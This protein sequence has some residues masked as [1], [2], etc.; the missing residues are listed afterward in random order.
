M[1]GDKPAQGVPVVAAPSEAYGPDRKEVARATTDYEGNYRLTGVPVGRYSV[2]PLAPTM[3]GP[4]DPM[5]GVNGRL[6][7]IGEGETVEKIDFS[8]TRGG[9]ITGR[10]TD[11]DGKPVI[12]ERLQLNA[13]DNPSIGRLGSYFNPYMYQTD[14]RGVYRLYGIPP[15]RYTLSVGISTQDGTVRVGMVTRGYFQRTYYPGETD[16]K[17]AGIIEVPEGGEV[18]DVDLKLGQ[19]SQS[20]IV[21]GRVVE[22]D[23]GRPV[24]NVLIGYGS[25]NP[26]EKRMGGYGFGQSRSDARGQFSL[27]GIVPGRFA[28]FI[29]SEGDQYSEPVPF[30]VTDADVG[31]LEI[32]VRRGATISGIAQLEGASER[33]VLARL[34]QL[35]IVSS[36]QSNGLGIPENRSATINTDGSFRLAGLSPGRAMF[37]IG[38]PQPKDIKLVRVE[39]DGAPQ[40]NG[41]EVTPGAEITNVRLIFEY[42]SG[43][44]RGQVRVE[45]GTLPDGARMFVFVQKPG[46]EPNATPVGYS[47]VDARGH[48][49]IE[50][51]AAGDYQIL[52]RAMFPPVAGRG[53]LA[54]AKQSVTVS[55]GIE[56][57]ANLTLDLKE[58]T[59]EGKEQ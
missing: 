56:T 28:A 44:I 48:F 26:T 31:G 46:D 23:T 24:S 21:T 32:K 35:T 12:E 50:G 25:Y 42:G 29:W 4:S 39:R 53:R 41:I 15:G 5:Y 45:N 57:E 7:I 27:E 14:D 20:F 34:S 2:S 16:I 6:V 58:R 8:L 40:P 17:S 9:V 55:N 10:I 38:Y 18:K 51:L 54:T 13:A 59:P 1:V 47:Q 36:V 43:S 33:S 3:I 49:F 11:A 22:A 30:Q 37:F 19:R 52:V